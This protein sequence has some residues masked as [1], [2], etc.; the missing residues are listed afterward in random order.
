M[1]IHILS[2]SGGKDSAATSLYLAE[3]GIDHYRVF[4]DTGWEHPLT[5]EYVRGALTEKLGPIF[6]VRG[7]RQMADLIRHKRMFPSR[8]KRFCT[9]DLKVKPLAK[10]V[11]AIAD[12]SG[13]EVINV[14]GVRAAE[15]AARRNLAEREYDETFD[16]EVWRPILRWSERDVIDIHARHGL[17]PNPLYLMGATRVGCWPC[18][19]ARKAEIKLIAWRTPRKIDEIRELE[20]ELE[21]RAEPLPDG[22]SA[23]RAFFQLPTADGATFIP[24]DQVVTWSRTLRGGKHE[25]KRLELFADFND[26]CA[27]WGMCGT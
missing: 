11:R 19:H 2:V 23:R 8:T 26:G 6:E 24:I 7:K 20:R 1:T 5:Y 15:S 21:E 22:R 12:A 13:E 3:Q 9:S 25:D 14:T 18:I 16:C 4:A 17:A 10:F 27:K